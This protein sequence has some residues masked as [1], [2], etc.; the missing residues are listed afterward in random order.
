MNEYLKHRLE[1][2]MDECNYGIDEILNSLND[3]ALEKGK[4]DKY[5]KSKDNIESLVNRYSFAYIMREMIRKELESL[6]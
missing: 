3:Y 5:I 6:E 4:Y 1:D 2:A